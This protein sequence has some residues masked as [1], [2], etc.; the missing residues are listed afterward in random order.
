[1]LGTSLTRALTIYEPHPNKSIRIMLISKQPAK[2]RNVIAR[3]QSQGAVNSKVSM[4][5]VLLCVLVLQVVLLSSGVRGQQSCSVGGST[6]YCGRVDGT[7]TVSGGF[8][9][10]CS[11][12]FTLCCSSTGFCGPEPGIANTSPASAYCTNCQAQFGTCKYP[13]GAA[14]APLTL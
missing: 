6:K 5:L 1:M 9:S 12:H 8:S 4:R 11:C 14:F 3:M 7:D 13:S 10:P 2:P